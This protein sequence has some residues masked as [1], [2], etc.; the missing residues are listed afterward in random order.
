MTFAVAGILG[1]YSKTLLLFFIPQIL[2]TIY[3]LPQLFRVI[4]CPRHRMPRLLMVKQPAASN[5]DEAKSHAESNVKQDGEDKF[6]IKSAPSIDLKASSEIAKKGARVNAPFISETVTNSAGDILVGCS[7]LECHP[8]KLSAVGEACYNLL[9]FTRLAHIVLPEGEDPEDLDH[10]VYISNLTLIN[11]CLY[12][13]GPLRE[14]ELTIALL[15]FQTACSAF[16][17]VVRFSLA[18]FIYD[19]VQ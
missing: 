7:Y 4:P 5:D 1:H 8:H 9:R 18:S 10:I 13:C 14:D 11:F 17:F 2:N 19:V 16:A 15:L 12:I 6:H 3:S